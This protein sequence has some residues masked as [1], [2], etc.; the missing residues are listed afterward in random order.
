MAITITPTGGA[1]GADVSGVDISKPISKEDFAVIKKAWLDNLVLRFRGKVLND[2]ELISFANNFGELALAPSNENSD[3]F[4][5]DH[6]IHPEIAVISNIVEAGRPIGGLGSG[7]AFWHTDSSFTDQP[8]A[9][10]FLHALE[11][12]PSGGDTSFCNLY[13][14]YET[15]SEKLK[16]RIEGRKAIHNF[17]YVASGQL[18]KGFEETTDVSKAPG[19]HHPMI[20]RHGESNRQALFLGRRLKSYILGLEVTE[21]EDLLTELWAHATQDKFVWT[22]KWKLGDLILWDNRCTMHKRESFD[23]SSRRLMHRTQTRGEIPV[24]A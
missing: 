1:L 14:A 16:N 21:S 8:P 4:G 10:S 18:R 5:G 20:R 22:Q 15:L 2:K 24:A 6:V 13:L 12:P 7:E 23:P 17:S 3:K 9:G 11:I 19:A